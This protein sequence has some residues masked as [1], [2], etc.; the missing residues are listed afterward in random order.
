M[1]FQYQ[2]TYIVKGAFASG[3][4]IEKRWLGISATPPTLRPA[5]RTPTGYKVPGIIFEQN[6]TTT[7]TYFAI[8]AS[9]VRIPST[10][11]ETI[12]PA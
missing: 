4:T 5:H 8:T 10:A 9:A 11:A 12:P 6:K 2:Y 7:H 1:Q 3:V